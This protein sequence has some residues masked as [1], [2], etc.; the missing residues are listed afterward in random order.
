MPR[1][2]IPT[3]RLR[4]QRVSI[5]PPYDVPHLKLHIPI[6]LLEIVPHHAHLPTKNPP[7]AGGAGHENLSLPWQTGA[8]CYRLGRFVEWGQGKMAL[9]MA[10]MADDKLSPR[11]RAGWMPGSGGRSGINSIGALPGNLPLRHREATAHSQNL[12]S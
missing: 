11:G 2:T 3:P 4:G 6:H 7:P 1:P 9:C 12:V 10:K 5:L 8:H